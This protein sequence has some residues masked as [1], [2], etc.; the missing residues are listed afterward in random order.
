MEISNSC[1][2]F[3]TV[4]TLNETDIH[5]F[6]RE[7]YLIKRGVL[8]PALMAQAR[9]RLWAN[10]PPPMVRHDPKTWVGP[11]AAAHDDHGDSR[12]GYEWKLRAPGREA[13]MIRLLA[14]DPN[15]WGMVEQL[16]GAGT[17]TTPEG[18]RGI[19]C[20]LPEGETPERTVNCHT[21]AHPFH[22][23]IVGY[24]DDVEPHGGGFIVWPGSHRAFYHDFIYRYANER[25]DAYEIHRKAI[26]T[27]PYV[28]C[29]G[30][31]GDIVFWHHRLGHSVGHNRSD[32][33]RL[34]VLYDYCKKDIDT[35]LLTGSDL[36]VDW[37]GIRA[38]E[39]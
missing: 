3:Q 33:L 5:F 39:D 11:F 16:L 6:K 7:G 24:I 38:V 8:D 34:A 30:Q 23:G 32:R 13:W 12:H 36:W 26:E 25:T 2:G 31:A 9:E 35:S 27:E 4:I 17:L 29:H 10:L 14:T 18:I 28:V 21:D 1:G 19:Y 20:V 22:L 15:V 37:P